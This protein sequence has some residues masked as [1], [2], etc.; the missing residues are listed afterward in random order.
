MSVLG[1]FFVSLDQRNYSG[2]ISECYCFFVSFNPNY[3]GITLCVEGTVWPLSFNTRCRFPHKL[4]VCT[5]VVF[6]R[7]LRYQQRSVGRA[8]VYANTD[9]LA[10]LFR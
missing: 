8:L 6:W 7:C 3:C 1:I 9:E 5:R 2:V 4:A 10:V